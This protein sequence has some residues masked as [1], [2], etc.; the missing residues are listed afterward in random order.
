MY[1]RKYVRNSKYYPI[2]YTV[3]IPSGGYNV[4]TAN[5]GMKVIYINKKL[6]GTTDASFTSATQKAVKKF[7]KSKGLS[8]TGV[9][10]L[11]TWLAMGYTEYDWYNLA[12]YLTPITTTVYSTK[13]DY[14]NRMLEVAKEYADKKTVYR[15]G[16]SGPPGTYADCS[17]LIYQCLYAIGINPKYNIIHHGLAEYE[18]TSRYLAADTMLGP[19]VS[20]SNIQPGD[21]VYYCRNGKTTVCHIAI[22]AGNGMIYDSWPS[23]GVTKRS[24][25][26]V[27]YYVCKVMRV[28]E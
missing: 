12:A 25:S 24:I 26:I 13:E 14:I 15:I 8:Q 6:L 5:I 16:C 7:Q 3:T 22:Y 11:T 28:I 20:Q 18:Y 23:I 4:S 17:G 21:L 10:D 2:E 9:V 1:V 19:T 27:G